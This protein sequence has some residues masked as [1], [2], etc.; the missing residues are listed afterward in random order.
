MLIDKKH[1]IKFG[2]SKAGVDP[3]EARSNPQQYY[4]LVE[5]DTKNWELIKE[6][7]GIFLFKRLTW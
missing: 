1:P 2:V 4:D 6:D 5:K 7:D 3:L